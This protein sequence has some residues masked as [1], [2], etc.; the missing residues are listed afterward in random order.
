M[1]REEAAAA[2]DRNQY[3]EEGSK[4]LFKAMKDAGLVAVFG[5]SDDLMEM[6]GA[7][8]DEVGAYEGTK[9]GF[10]PKGLLTSEC[11]EGKDCPYFKRL[12]KTAKIVEAVWDEGGYSW[13]YKTDIPHSTFEILE[14]DDPYCR[15]I[16]FALSDA[17]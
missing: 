1:T 7:V 8:D 9:V 17:A 12:A 10:T 16:V 13:I 14:D 2:L 6:R 11:D 4:E 3:R 5:A 15:G